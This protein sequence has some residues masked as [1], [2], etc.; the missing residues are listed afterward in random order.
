MTDWILFDCM[1]TLI[2]MVQI[3]TPADYAAWAFEKSEAES[4][5]TDFDAFYRDY[6]MAAFLIEGELPAFKE[7]EM[8]ER[9]ARALEISGKNCDAA[10]LVRNLDETFWGRYAKQC[11]VKRQVLETVS[12]LSQ[13]YRMGVVS[14]FK[15]KSGVRALLAQT[16]LMEYFEFTVNSCEVG[17]KKPHDY[18][19]HRAR[20]LSV[21]DFERIVFIGDDLLNDYVKPREL[22]CRAILYDP[23]NRH[24]D[25]ASR[26]EG[27]E[28]LKIPGRLEGEGDGK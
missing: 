15:V 26:I 2:D 11:Y 28:E 23:S 21:V 10:N 20:E 7:Y 5:W 27:F 19:Y 6:Q 9:Y 16:G 1:E 8:K 25:I 17:W 12:F 24:L 18:I 14:N 3:P 4:L 13:T 22:G